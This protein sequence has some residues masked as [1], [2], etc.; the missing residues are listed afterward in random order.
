[1]VSSAISDWFNSSP[2]FLESEVRNKH[3]NPLIIPSMLPSW[4]Y[5]GIPATSYFINSQKDTLDIWRVLEAL[6]P[7]TSD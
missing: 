4:G 1:M 7:G 6:V 5:L 2:S 3:F